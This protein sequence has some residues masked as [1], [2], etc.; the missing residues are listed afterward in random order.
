[1]SDKAEVSNKSK[2]S[3]KLEKFLAGR[4][5]ILNYFIP[6]KGVNDIFE[7]IRNRHLDRFQDIDSNELALYKVG[8]V[9]DSIIINTLRNNNVFIVERS[10]EME[11]QDRIFI[12]FPI[13][14][15]HIYS[16]EKRI[17]VIVCPPTE[18]VPHK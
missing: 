18:M 5:I 10:V 14:P 1:M 2:T 3:D 9:A 13:Q 11:P 16:G 8:F 7:A 4:D 12:H 6:G 17:N 15:Q